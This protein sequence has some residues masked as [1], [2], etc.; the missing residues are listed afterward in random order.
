[1]SKKYFLIA[2]SIFICSTPSIAQITF[3]E[4]FVTSR[5]G[6]TYTE[7]EIVL[8]VTDA[9]Q[10]AANASG[11][12]QTWDFSGAAQ[13]DSSTSVLNYVA[14]PAELPGSDLTFFQG[15]TFAVT[16]EEEGIE[17]VAY[18]ALD[19]GS[20]KILGTWAVGDFDEDGNEDEIGSRYDP[21]SQDVVFPATYESTW[22]DS[23]ALI[24]EGIS[25]DTEVESSSSVVDGWGT[26]IFPDGTSEE[27]L[28]LRIETQYYDNQTLEPAELEVD[29]E[30]LALSG[31]SIGLYMDEE[32]TV[33]EADYFIDME[34]AVTSVEPDAPE[35]P[36]LITLDQNY[37]NPFNPTTLIP[38]RLNEAAQVKLEVYTLTGERVA[39][40]VNR[41]QQAG[42]YEARFDAQTLASGVYVYRLQTGETTIT[43]IMSL[44]R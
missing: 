11:P 41:A 36:A 8:E 20:I 25:F 18:F 10:T 17:N 12:N 42:Q 9:M 7:T 4:E 39:T 33:L 23:T 3:T 43:R 37:P 2:L 40:L 30:F 31:R 21:P 15:A 14:L 44:L 5:F 24:F 6:K 29:I 38:Y 16:G 28:R 34:S 1:M 13:L 26:V 22:T 27:A 19:N 35:L 32:G